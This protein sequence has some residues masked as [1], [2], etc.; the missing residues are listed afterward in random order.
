MRT[1]GLLSLLCL[2]S[3]AYIVGFDN[4]PKEPAG[5]KSVSEASG[6]CDPST[7]AAVENGADDSSKLA[8]G[9]IAVIFW[10]DSTVPLPATPV[11]SVLV[12]G[13]PSYLFPPGATPVTSA[14]ANSSPG[15]LQ[16]QVQLPVEV[17]PGNKTLELKRKGK[18]VAQTTIALSKFAPG[19]FTANGTGRGLAVAEH[20]DGSLVTTACP[21]PVGSAV[22]LYAEGLGP[23]TPVV[24]TGDLPPVGKLVTTT[25]T[26][27]VTVDG[28]DANVFF[29]VLS[30]TLIGVY[31][32]NFL[33]PDVA[34][35]AML[36]HIQI[37]GKYSNTAQ[38]PVGPNTCVP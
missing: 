38:L 6:Y 12:N 30:P 15:Y 8:P 14:L 29:A 5:H 33:V 35:G 13:S 24:A 3:T 32:V 28:I 11:T 27:V 10:C 23:T 1:L 22:S 20:S 9:G 19:I 31:Q 36:L 37:G 17:Y 16:L 25:T 34:S 18:V 21:A 2:V 7:I 26:P 4:V